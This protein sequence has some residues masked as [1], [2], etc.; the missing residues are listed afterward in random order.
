MATVWN[1][2]VGTLNRWHSLRLVSD[3]LATQPLPYF[4]AG[5]G[6]QILGPFDILVD[7]RLDEQVLIGQPKTVNDEPLFDSWLL[8]G[9]PVLRKTAGDVEANGLFHRDFSLSRSRSDGKTAITLR[10]LRDGER[11]MPLE[12][13]SMLR[14]ESVTDDSG[15]SL[16]FFQSDPAKRQEIARE[17]DDVL[18]VILPEPSLAGQ[19]SVCI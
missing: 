3:R 2:V 12:L 15:R 4:Y 14:I 7:D 5:L 8:S 16:E 9:V 1:S 11:V 17:G 13:S 6:G 10:A 18:F 19:T